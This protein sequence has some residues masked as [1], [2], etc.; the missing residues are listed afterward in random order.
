MTLKHYDKVLKVLLVA[1]P[2]AQCNRLCCDNGSVGFHESQLE[3]HRVWIV[4]RNKGRQQGRSGNVEA[5]TLQV[6]QT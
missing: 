3:D 4:G 5:D 2:F 1:H 6:T